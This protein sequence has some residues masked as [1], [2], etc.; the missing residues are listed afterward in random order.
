MDR[1]RKVLARARKEL[2][3]L[4]EAVATGDIRKP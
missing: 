2:K 1:I 3:V 4:R